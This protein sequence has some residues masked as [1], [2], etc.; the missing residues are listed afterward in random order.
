MG[1]RLAPVL[2]AWLAAGPAFAGSWYVA[3][4]EIVARKTPAAQAAEVGRL[5][6]GAAAEVLAR[7][8]HWLKV[9]LEGGKEGWVPRRA[10]SPKA[11]TEGWL[12]GRGRAALSQGNFA[13]AAA[14]LEL[15]VARGTK[16]RSCLEALGQAQRARGERAQEEAALARIRALERWLHGRWCD[17]AQKIALVLTEDGK[18][19]L[20]SDGRAVG[21]GRYELSD[22]ELRLSDDRGRAG[23]LSLYV[24]TRGRE[25][26][27][28]ARS[29][30]ELQRIFCP[31]P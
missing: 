26:V 7:E 1:Q 4:P 18:Y 20:Q 25:K 30:E 8:R 27:L 19:T 5:A 13:R 11:L 9:R 16:S 2:L 24:R 28:V 23:D 29:T 10:M 21:L 14:Y 22:D 31:A 12:C 6:L 15:A 17:A 3:Q